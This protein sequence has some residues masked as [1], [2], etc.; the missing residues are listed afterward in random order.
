MR[1]K[2]KVTL[3][4]F[5]VV[6]LGCFSQVF[7]ASNQNTK[8][9]KNIEARKSVRLLDRTNDSGVDQ[10]TKLLMHMDDNNFKDECGNNPTNNN[11]SLDTTNKKIGSGSASFNGTDSY[12]TIPASKDWDL[13]SEDFTLSCWIKLEDENA[14]SSTPKEIVECGGVYN[15]SNASW[16]F[17]NSGKG[18]V[19]WYCSTGT[20]LGTVMFSKNFPAVN[21]KLFHHYEVDRQG[22]NFYFFLDGNLVSTENNSSPIKSDSQ[23]ILIGHSYFYFEGNID[24]LRLSVGIARHTS[25]FTPDGIAAEAISLN[26]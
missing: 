22:S 9:K 26:K 16:I 21:D 4:V 5:L 14:S 25:D 11:V 23:S 12:L 13:G 1:K 19:T 8:L 15:V 6:V 7:A 20:G 3:V 24:E 18:V 10:Y 2:F 17:T